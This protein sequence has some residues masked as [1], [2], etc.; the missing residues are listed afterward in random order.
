VSFFLHSPAVISSA[1]I[2]DPESD[3][4]AMDGQHIYTWRLARERETHTKKSN[5][6]EHR[7]WVREG[8]RVQ[9]AGNPMTRRI[10]ALLPAC[11]SISFLLLYLILQVSLFFFCGERRVIVEEFVFHILPRNEIDCCCINGRSDT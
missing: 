8:C 5:V 11:L 1:G 3:P 10:P 7:L 9:H 4:R 2:N 6:E